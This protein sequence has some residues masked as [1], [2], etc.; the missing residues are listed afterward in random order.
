[1]IWM[2]S[3]EMKLAR[4]STQAAKARAQG[5]LGE[6]E[7]LCREIVEMTGTTFGQ[8]D[9]DYIKAL[10]DLAEVLEA[11]QKYGEALNLRSRIANFQTAKQ[12]QPRPN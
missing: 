11:E 6:A 12:K 5:N 1:M 2:A 7:E 3:R 4:L 8:F 10:L 9:E